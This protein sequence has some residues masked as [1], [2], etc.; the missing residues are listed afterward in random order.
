MRRTKVA[1]ERRLARSLATAPERLLSLAAAR[2]PVVR[3]AVAS[4][5]SSP[6]AAL[7]A[8]AQ[9][10]AAS[11]RIAVATHPA[12]PPEVLDALLG[13]THPNVRAAALSAAIDK[14]HG[15]WGLTREN[16][17]A[18]W[19]VRALHPRWWR[20]T[21]EHPLIRQAAMRHPD[22]RPGDRDRN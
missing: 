10:N 6:A 3:S 11:L 5:P 19:Y 20:L 1:R 15:A 21:P 8:C 17:A 14:A 7:T 9:N 2:D 18:F 12:T 22:A 4:N 13:D 16:T